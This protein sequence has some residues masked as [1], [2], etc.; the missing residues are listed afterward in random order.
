VVNDDLESCVAEVLAILAAE[1]GGETAALRRRL[2]PE[3]ARARLGDP[4]A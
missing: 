3:V 4:G 1:R 2:A